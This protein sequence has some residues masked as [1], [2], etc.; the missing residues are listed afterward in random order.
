MLMHTGLT[1]LL[2]LLLY[3]ALRQFLIPHCLLPLCL[4]WFVDGTL[5]VVRRYKYRHEI[6]LLRVSMERVKM[7]ALRFYRV[8]KTYCTGVLLNTSR[9]NC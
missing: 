3:L 5:R 4:F 9:T 7:I 2:Y 6:V 8:G 1:I